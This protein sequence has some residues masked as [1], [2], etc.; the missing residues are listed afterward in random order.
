MA[1]KIHR[2]IG[3]RVRRAAAASSLLFGPFFTRGA[4]SHVR[5]L[6]CG[7]RVAYSG[8]GARAQRRFSAA[9]GSLG[10]SRA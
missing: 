7:D 8:A 10:R 1:G 3:R 4:Q 5:L 2:N 6:R 9:A